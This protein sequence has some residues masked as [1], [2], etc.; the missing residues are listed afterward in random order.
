MNINELN[1]IKERALASMG[2]READHNLK[3]IQERTVL[4]CGGTG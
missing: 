2:P 3:D 4:V 1:A